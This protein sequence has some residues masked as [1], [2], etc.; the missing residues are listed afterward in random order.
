LHGEFLHTWIFRLLSFILLLIF[1]LELFDLF[2][3]LGLCTSSFFF[4]A[5]LSLGLLSSGNWLSVCNRCWCSESLFLDNL[6]WLLMGCWLLISR[7]RVGSGNGVFILLLSSRL[8]LILFLDWRYVLILLD[9][10]H[11]SHRFRLLHLRNR[12]FH[13]G[14]GGCSR[15]S[16]WLVIILSFFA[17]V[18]EEVASAW[19]LHIFCEI[20]KNK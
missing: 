18:V 14:S 5:L 17:I 6:S 2:E 10:L 20:C 1:D 11:L 7:L 16:T 9:L 15:L 19:F 4:K 8:R 13:W 3:K 12:L